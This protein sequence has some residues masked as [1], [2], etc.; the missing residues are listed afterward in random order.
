MLSE[1]GKSSLLMQNWLDALDRH[2]TLFL[3][4]PVLLCLLLVGGILFLQENSDGRI[5]FDESSAERQRLLALEQRFV[6]QNSLLILLSKKDGDLFDPESLQAIVR[7]TEQAWRLPHVV[8]VNSLSNFQHIV[9]DGDE[10]IIEDLF[11]GDS[12][13]DAAALDRIKAYALS[14][15]DLAGK[16]L[17]PDGGTTA[18]ALNI[19]APRGD[20]TA[21]G[22][23]MAAV[24]RLTAE[25][26]QDYPGLDLHVTGD[27]PLD[28]AFGEASGQDLRT[29]FPAFLLVIYL[30]CYFFFRSFTVAG[31]ILVM[32]IL[33]VGATMGGAGY[34]GIDLT[35]GTSG[36]PVILITIALAD[37]IHLLAAT[38]RGIIA[39]LADRAAVERAIR[40]NFLPIT[41]TSFTTFIGFISLNFNDAP[42]FRDMGNLVAL[43]ILISYLITFSFF[44]A[45]LSRFDL[46]RLLP[47]SAT[48]I[49]VS[50]SFIARYSSFLVRWRR[51]VVASMLLL[52]VAIGAGIGRIELDDDWVKYFDQDNKFRQDT[53]FA[54]QN[55]SGIDSV[56][57]VLSAGEGGYVTD[58]D[59]LHRLDQFE[60]WTRAQPEIG[61][62]TSIVSLF[63]KMNFHMNGGRAEFN[64]ISDNSDLNAQYLLMYEMSLP[65]GLDLNDRIDI[66]KQATRLTVTG[67]DLTSRQMRDMDRKVSQKL[68]QMNLMA[69]DATGSGIPLMFANLSERNIK[70][71]LAG[72]AFALGLVS[73]VIIFAF[74]S[75]R[76]GLISFAVNILPII[77][78]FGVWGWIYQYVGLSLTVVA[79]I[80]FGIVVDDSIHFITK[81]TKSR[82]KEGGQ[83][84]DVVA[85]TFGE[86]GGALFITTAV[87]IMGFLMLSFSTFQP[88]WALG[89][90]SAIMILIALIYDFLLLPALLILTGSGKSAEA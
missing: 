43:G 88:T 23:I 67:R 26:K 5:F 24:A 35:T 74:R 57:Y 90:I 71:M 77:L 56:E 14:E 47:A 80:A 19:V 17:S 22:D 73:L 76:L 44:P 70:S 50:P 41:L 51:A 87:L 78:G 46:A 89:L 85:A 83:A 60:D 2:V 11:S 66:D 64:R 68:R 3:L 62:V 54:V 81:Y 13:L 15:P 28:H 38:R 32:M 55:L 69:A 37:F 25:V 59:F 75:F 53:E 34:L 52:S 10:L 79:A 16:I 18:I 9:S 39:G 86:V 21:I 45:L 61:Q 33:V 30:L 6:A 82:A 4:L 7:V 8:R 72:I 36:V 20:S 1:A 84:K 58:G 29:L 49:A 48:K 31:I 63:R 27:V 65:V 42:P 40:N 12:P